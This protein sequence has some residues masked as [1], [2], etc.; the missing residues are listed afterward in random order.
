M[1]AR[2]INGLAEFEELVGQEI[3]VS[4][5]LT[6]TQEQINKFADATLDHQ[7]IHTDTERAKTESPFGTTIAHGYLTLSL[8]P[9]FWAQI[10]DV[11]QVK[12]LV[13]YGL[14]DFKFNQPVKVNDQVRIRVFLESITNLRGI[15]KTKM[16]A[17][18]EILDNPKPAYVGY[19]LFLYHFND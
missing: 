2:I 7:W 1:S 16:K 13:N 14:E 3:G 8:L 12:M 4:E 10:A 5:Y 6:I 18:M 9:H 15:I 11:R 17:T 19:I